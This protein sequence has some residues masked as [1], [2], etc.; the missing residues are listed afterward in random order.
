VLP[1]AGGAALVLAV[2]LLFGRRAAALGSAA[3]VL[4]AFM[5][6]NYEARI[7]AEAPVPTWENT[8]RVLPWKL[9]E[10]SLGFQWLPRA[11]LALVVVGLVSRWLGLAAGRLLPERGWWAANLLVWLPRIGAVF[12]VSGWLVLGPAAQ[13]E[14]WSHLRWELAGTMLLVWLVADGFARG[15]FSAEVSAYL[16]ASLFVGG[17][18]VLYAGTLG[19]MELAVIVG[20]AMFGIAVVNV[21]ARPGANGEKVLATGAIPAAVAFLPGLI[22]GCRPSLA[23]HKVPDICFWL[24]ALAPLLLA[25]FIVP[26]ISR[27]NRWLLLALRVLLVLAPLAVALMLAGKHEKLPYEK[28]EE[29]SL[30]PVSA[31]LF[32]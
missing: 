6:G 14:E 31:R 32:F 12:A 9:D 18:V 28:E 19:F 5:W 3:A 24:T 25:P 27:Q 11:A 20:S 16:G 23:E 4:V 8:F 30:N 1:G 2:F 21:I 29:W 10:K 7:S 26:R 22:L 13:A 15:G 17:A